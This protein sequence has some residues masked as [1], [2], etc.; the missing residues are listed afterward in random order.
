MEEPL[1]QYQTWALKVSIHC[2]G[3]KT[4]VKKVLQSIEGVY[5]VAIDSQHKVTVTGNIDAQTLIRKLLKT[6]KHAELWPEK[7]AGKDKKSGKS[8]SNE[9]GGDSKNGENSEEEEE[10]SPAGNMEANV[11]P[12]KN[13]EKG[14]KVVRF[15]GV[16][17]IAGDQREIKIDGKLPGSIPATAEKSPV[18][19]QKSNA[20]NGGGAEKNNGGA[21]GHGKKKKKK[22]KKGNSNNNSN[23]GSASA[24]A[25][26][27]T[28]VEGPRV[29]SPNQVTDQINLTPS[30]QH[31][32][33]YPP[34]YSP[35]QAYVVS[36]NA[37]HPTTCTGPIW[38][39]SPSP[40]LYACTYP[41]VYPEYPAPALSTFEILSDE[42]PNGCYI[43]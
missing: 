5:A 22:G 17:G 3:C 1:L 13:S 4:K 31:M 18:S 10:E 27:S 15:A 33:Q 9:K 34:S 16:D 2:Q 43:M 42:N 41:E 35:Y 8:S 12:A 19:E 32:F 40:Y 26:S 28:G 21:G 37:A 39:M 20:N 25:P 30:N 38:Y 29:T 6:G 11:N 23:A 7:P 24:L 36:Y 14:T